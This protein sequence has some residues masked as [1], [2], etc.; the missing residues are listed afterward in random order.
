[1]SQRSASFTY[2]ASTFLSLNPWLN[3]HSGRR[4][5]GSNTSLANGQ[6]FE[7]CSLWQNIRS[8]IVFFLWA[9]NGVRTV[10]AS[11]D[12]VFWIVPWKVRRRIVPVIPAP[13]SEFCCSTRQMAWGIVTRENLLFTG[14]RRK[15][16]H[17]ELTVV[18]SNNS[19]HVVE[20][21]RSSLSLSAISSLVVSETST[22]PLGAFFS[23]LVAKST[24]TLKIH[25]NSHANSLIIFILQ[26][27]RSASCI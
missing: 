19:F 4:S 8:S 17:I 16:G 14:N 18:M 25:Y 5:V 7:S 6:P 20:S 21:S 13:V 24:A 15:P 11:R 1:M 2:D 26:L 22:D 10:L 12:V 23:I 27:H 9:L 3:L